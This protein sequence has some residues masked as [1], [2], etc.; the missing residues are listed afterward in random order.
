[1]RNTV[2]HSQLQATLRLAQ[3]SVFYDMTLSPC[4]DA[5]RLH[6]HT[7][8]QISRSSAGCLSGPSATLCTAVHERQADVITYVRLTQRRPAAQLL[9]R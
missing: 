4:A 9:Q 6:V 8:R 5:A 3:S 7:T 2:Q 1:M